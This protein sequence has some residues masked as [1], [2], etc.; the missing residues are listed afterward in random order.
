[1]TMNGRKIVITGSTGTIGCA[2]A[3]VFAGKGAQL[4][5]HCHERRDVAE[6]LCEITRKMGARAIVIK[7]D[8]SKTENIVALVSESIKAMGGIDT[9]I[10]AAATFEETP[11][12]SVDEALWNRVIDIDLKAAFFLAQEIA[13]HMKAAG[14][15]MIFLSDLSASKP[16]GSYLPYCMS[17]AGIDAMVKGLAKTFAP[18]IRV[19]AIAPYVVS[20]PEGLSDEGWNDLITKIPLKRPSSPQEIARIARMLCEND[21]TITGQVIVVDGGRMLR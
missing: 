1:M 8:L 16:Y 21:S 2:I 13:T 3:K 12:G 15:N 19:N 17:K 7:S 5:L 11:I 20:R 9:L 10:H 14:G 4:V 6:E 18:K